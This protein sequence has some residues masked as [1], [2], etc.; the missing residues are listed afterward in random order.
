MLKTGESIL[1]DPSYPKNKPP[2]WDWTILPWEIIYYYPQF[3]LWI[4]ETMEA[5]TCEY[6]LTVKHAA[7]L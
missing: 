5:M 1:T 2:R 6:Q 7:I 3:K 4:S